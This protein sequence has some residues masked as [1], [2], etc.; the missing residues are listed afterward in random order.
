MKGR[1]YCFA[2]ILALASFM[3]EAAAASEAL[4]DKK[5]SSEL[6]LILYAE[7]NLKGASCSISFENPIE[8]RGV[9][10]GFKGKN[11]GSLS[12]GR[13]PNSDMTL[14]LLTDSQD[15]EVGA[16]LCIQGSRDGDANRVDRAFLSTWPP[17]T[18]AL[19]PYIAVKNDPRLYK[20]VTKVI[21]S[22][23]RA[24]TVAM[25]PRVGDDPL[26]T[27]AVKQWG[28]VDVRA[29]CPG[30]DFSKTD[31]R[32]NISENPGNRKLC[33]NGRT[34]SDS[35]CYSTTKPEYE[36]PELGGPARGGGVEFEVKGDVRGKLQK[37]KY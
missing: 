34:S 9:C 28:E 20:D 15:P 19:R 24:A 32:L 8:T 26:C 11:I 4:A 10:D 2:S 35:T 13:L 36:V 21:Y 5:S 37:V 6:V 30:T 3:V 22:A 23:E 7:A 29:K 18:E 33:F 14:C 1:F 25:S 27:F 31:L 16:A 17:I 12:M